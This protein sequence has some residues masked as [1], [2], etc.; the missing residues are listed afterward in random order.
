MNRRQAPGCTELEGTAATESKLPSG[1]T[2][3]ASEMG[4]KPTFAYL[5]R[6]HVVSEQRGEGIAG[7]LV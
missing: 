1:S 2:D 4:A 7:M 6:V 3:G 5:R